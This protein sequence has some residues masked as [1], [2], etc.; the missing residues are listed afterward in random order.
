[1]PITKGDGVVQVPAHRPVSPG[2]DM[3]AL[4]R[5]CGAADKAFAVT[6]S[7]YLAEQA[8]Q[9]GYFYFQLL[10]AFY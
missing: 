1:M 9:L 3:S 6:L 8:V 10:N 5:F 4:K 7:Y 2:K